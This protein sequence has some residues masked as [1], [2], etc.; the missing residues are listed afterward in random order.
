MNEIICPNCKYGKIERK[1][2]L[3]YFMGL[4]SCPYCK[5]EVA[6][7]VMHELLLM[8]V[9]PAIACVGMVLLFG[10]FS[11]SLYLSGSVILS[12]VFLFLLYKSPIR[13][14]EH[15]KIL[16]Q[17]VLFGPTRPAMIGPLIIFGFGAMLWA[18]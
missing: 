18:A 3:M 17:K 11:I 1:N 14:V 16:G 15:K 5:G 9:A 13:V 4:I 10:G 8:V 7:A 6:P 2:P 12:V